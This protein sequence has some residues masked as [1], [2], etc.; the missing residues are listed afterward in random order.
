LCS[1]GATVRP[2]EVDC[3]CSHEFACLRHLAEE[4]FASDEDEETQ[5]CESCGDTGEVEYCPSFNEE[6]CSCS[7]HSFALCPDC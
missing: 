2:A 4:I 7:G 1:R 6:E 5:L 3:G